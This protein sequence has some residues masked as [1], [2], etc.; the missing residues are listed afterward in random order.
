MARGGHRLRAAGQPYYGIW[1]PAFP[2]ALRATRLFF[3]A[4]SR[5]LQ[6]VHQGELF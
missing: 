5:S 4:P 6:R 2:A 1:L 3:A